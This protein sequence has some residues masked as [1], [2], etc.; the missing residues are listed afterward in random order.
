MKRVYGLAAVLAVAIGANAAMALDAPAA[1]KERQEFYKDLGKQMK[2]LMEE[3]KS[4]SP[5]AAE[6]K[7]F[8]AAIDT[9]APR[10]PSLFPAGTGPE[11][12]VKTAAKAEI[13]QKQDEFKKDA[14]DFAAAAHALD[15][16]A[17][18]GDVAAVKDAAGKLGEACKTCHQT[19]REKEH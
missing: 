7:K 10:I 19:F 4:S 9:A 3:L 14:G 6:L 12:G 16:A 17:Q 8:S 2:G 18:S 13:W 15:V 1:I 11:A 5:N